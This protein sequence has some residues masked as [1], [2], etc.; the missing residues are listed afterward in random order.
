MNARHPSTLLPVFDLGCATHLLL[1]G[2]QVVGTRATR[3]RRGSRREGDDGRR[4]QH[5]RRSSR[6]VMQNTLRPT[7]QYPRTA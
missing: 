2:H 7:W 1:R 4:R 3:S 5:V 6:Y